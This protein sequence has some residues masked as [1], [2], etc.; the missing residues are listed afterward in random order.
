MKY[1][2]SIALF[3]LRIALG[4]VFFYAGW[5]KLTMQGGFSAKGFLLNL[6]G[7]FSAFYLPLAGSHTID[8]LVVWGE[9]L[10]GICLILGL[11]VRFASF[12]GI[13]LMLL[14]YFAQYPPKNAFLVDDHIIYALVLVYFMVSGAGR[15]WGMDKKLE[16]L[17][18][19]FKSLMG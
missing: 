8:L 17:L 14:F 4:W 18:P 19:Q 7:T 3:S 15:V 9:I 10:I 13:V 11:L 16:K 6:H 1:K 12:W 2:S 5:E